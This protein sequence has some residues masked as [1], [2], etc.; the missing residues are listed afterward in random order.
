MDG[1]PVTDG[2]QVSFNHRVPSFILY[3]EQTELKF[4][5]GVTELILPK[6]SA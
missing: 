3:E 2:T 5:C 6:Y 4:L 1:T